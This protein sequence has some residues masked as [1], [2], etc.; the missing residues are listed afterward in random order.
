MMPQATCKKTEKKEL[1][2]YV[3]RHRQAPDD[4]LLCNITHYLHIKT[5]SQLMCFLNNNKNETKEKE[6]A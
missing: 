3:D 2:S 4:F 5:D 1:L 6:T